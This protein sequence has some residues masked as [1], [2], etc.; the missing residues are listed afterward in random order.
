MVRRSGKEDWKKDWILLQK[1]NNPTLTMRGTTLFRRYASQYPKTMQQFFW[2]S[3]KPKRIVHL[4]QSKIVQNAARAASGGLSGT[5]WFHEWLWG[6]EAYLRFEIC[7][8]TLFH[9]A[10][11]SVNTTRVLFIVQSSRYTQLVHN[12]KWFPITLIFLY[13]FQWVVFMFYIFVEWSW[14][15]V[16]GFI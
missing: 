16:N 3:S 4:N 15:V 2:K 8:S 12:F 13:D 11:M 6:A 10:A 7:G 5:S 9:Y 14:M 1:S